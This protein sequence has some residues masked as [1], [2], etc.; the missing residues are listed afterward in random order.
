MH[1]VGTVHCW[2]YRI[3]M[4]W[5]KVFCVQ[6]VNL[7]GDPGTLEDG[8]TVSASQSDGFWHEV[9]LC[10]KQMIVQ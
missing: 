5:A 7:G 4:L 3:R 9:W 8:G 10:G 6:W 2:A 1:G